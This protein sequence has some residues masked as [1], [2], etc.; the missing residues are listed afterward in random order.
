MQ[1]RECVGCGYPIADPDLWVCPNCR[2]RRFSRV[3]SKQCSRCFRVR[4][5]DECRGGCSACHS[6]DLIDWNPSEADAARQFEDWLQDE[7][8]SASSTSPLDFLRHL[9]DTRIEDAVFGA[10]LNLEDRLDEISA[11]HRLHAGDS[12]G[13]SDTALPCPKCKQG[14]V[15]RIRYRSNR[16]G[17]L[18][19]LLA[20]EE[21][22]G[23]RQIT[24]S[25]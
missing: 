8:I 11:V 14:S 13:E 5:L 24:S 12:I 25:Q 20:C 4:R 23:Y 19:E 16:G 7:A 21:G 2:A 3:A 17:L 10:L 18:A 15:T 9:E 22:C 1:L 6:S